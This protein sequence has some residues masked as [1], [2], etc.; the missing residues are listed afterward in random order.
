MT[1]PIVETPPAAGDPAA[2]ARRGGRRG[3]GA[4]AA[5]ASIVVL[6]LVHGALIWAGLGGLAGLTNGWPPLWGD[7]GL[8][9][10]HAVLA[11]EFLRTTGTTAGYDPSFMAGYP[12][13]ILTLPSSTVG[14]LFVLAFG[15]ARSAFASKL[16]LLVA[17][18]LLPGLMAAV[19]L[20]MRA[21]PGASVIAVA[22]YLAYFW[23]DFPFYYVMVGMI[24]YAVSVPLGLL[25]VGALAAYLARGGPGRWLGA[26]AACAGVFLIHPTSPMLVGPAGLAAYVVA[27][28]R[29]RR[30]GRPMP[31]SRHLGLWAMVPLVLAVNAFWFVPG[32]RLASTL[33]ATDFAFVHPE[34]TVG[35]LAAIFTEEE[36]IQAVLIA[37]APVG[38]VVLARRDAVA[39]AGLAGFMAS[40]FGW[41]YLAGAFRSLD[42]LQP[43]RH[44]YAL[45]AGACVA[46]G[47]G[48]GEVLVRLRSARVPRLDRWAAVGLTLLGVRMFGPSVSSQSLQPMLWGPE[49]PLM[50]R[51]PTRFLDLIDR[52]R[53]RVRPGERL[54]YEETG[55]GDEGPRDPFNGRHYSP[56]LPHLLGVEVIG[57]P[58]LH[59]HLKTNFTQFGE[60][61]L[62]GDPDWGRD[63]FVRYARLYRPAAIACWS[64]KA[65]AFCSANPDLVKVV[66]DDGTLLIGRVLGFEGAAARG[67][68]EVTASPNRIEVK[69]AV[70]GD[71]G[72]VVLRYHAAPHLASEPPVE[73]VPVTLEDD[74]VPFIAF[75]PIGQTVVFRMRPAPW[76]P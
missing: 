55:L 12:M 52:L 60:G 57:G 45:Y 19:P 25:T 73:I 10:H 43:G 9:F 50:S 28:V 70:A 44:T 35:R 13:S 54:L 4:W 37:L 23:T 62:F 32:V 17:A 71:D 58:Y 66:D 30:G 42:L 48:L 61:K 40:G 63:R 34:S 7:H 26:A 18:T 53:R 33:G 2:A 31:A 64:P 56:I 36:P 47:I 21:R 1:T 67:Q 51:P 76:S 39:A 65:R 14:E 5:A 27:A 49:F 20:V 38:L 72:L 68:A 46:G 41:G 69:D 6:G 15:K 59:I 74:P 11:S 24:A 29:A 16:Y 3:R 8:Q 75:R 22:L